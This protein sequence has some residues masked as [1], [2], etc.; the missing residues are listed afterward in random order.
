MG[1]APDL[2]VAFV[3]RALDG[4][5][6]AARQLATA[7]LPV[8]HAR[9]GRLLLRFRSA[10][11]QRDVR[12]EVEDLTQ[13]TMLA[14]FSSGGRALRAWTPDRGLALPQFVGLLAERE[15]YTVLR[16]RRK[17]PWTDDP[18]EDEALHANA[19]VQ[20]GP[21]LVIASRELALATVARAFERLSE[22]GREMF[23]WLFVD[24]RPVEEICEVTG[25]KPGAVYVWRNRITQLLREIA[26]QL[27]SEPGG[28]QSPVEVNG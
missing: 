8:V 27:Q 2:S 13:H 25:M 5:A 7:L 19:D 17:S 20:P 1:P 18:T 16:S 4:D 3:R 9:V 21:E 22:R 24:D 23:Q 15:V 12:Q 6:Q 28:S 10:A 26:K 14:L 11:R